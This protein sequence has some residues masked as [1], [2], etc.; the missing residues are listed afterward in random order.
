MSNTPIEKQRLPVDLVEQIEREIALGNGVSGD[1]LLAAI[2]QSVGFQLAARLRDVL[3]K[4]SVSP[5]K[6]RGRPSNCKGREDLA[7]EK[8]DARY[9]KLLFEYKDEAA[10]PDPTH[11]K[12]SV[13]RRTAPP[14]E[15]AYQKLAQE[16]AKDFGNIDWLALRNKH[17]KWNT[18][19]YHSAI[20]HVDSEDYDAE[21]DRL[22]PAPKRRS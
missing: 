20:N 13:S 15:R 4:F 18:G 2:E 12:R 14:S 5:V 7:M 22:F 1:I 11:E 21:I 6:R 16:M 19:H 3:S 8:L 10:R 9:R 17:S